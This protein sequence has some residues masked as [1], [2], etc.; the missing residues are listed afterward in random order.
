VRQRVAGAPCAAG[1]L[2]LAAA[3]EPSPDLHP[4]RHFSA[5]GMIGRIPQ[6]IVVSTDTP[7]R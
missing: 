3:Y 2:T 5:V 4:V 6:A 7:A 1:S